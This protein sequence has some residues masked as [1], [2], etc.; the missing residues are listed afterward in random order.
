MVGGRNPVRVSP[1]VREHRPGPPKGGLAYMTQSVLRRGARWVVK[2]SGSASLAMEAQIACLF[3]SGQPFEEQA[4]GLN[5]ACGVANILK[6]YARRVP[7]LL[8]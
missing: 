7:H 1:Q 4:P 2:V 3:Q 5:S 8:P 6:V